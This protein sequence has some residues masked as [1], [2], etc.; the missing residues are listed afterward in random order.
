MIFRQFLKYFWSYSLTSFLLQAQAP[1]YKQTRLKNNACFFFFPQRLGLSLELS[2]DIHREMWRREVGRERGRQ[3]NKLLPRLLRVY[4]HPEAGTPPPPRRAAPRVAAGSLDSKGC[5]RACASTSG[6]REGGRRAVPHSSFGNR[7]QISRT[8]GSGCS[9]TCSRSTRR[10]SAGWASPSCCRDAASK[11]ASD[12]G[13]G[14]APRGLPSG[15]PHLSLP[16]PRRTRPAARTPPQPPRPSRRP[17]RSAPRLRAALGRV[18]SAA[19]CGAPRTHRASPRRGRSRLP[20][21]PALPPGV[22]RGP[23]G[24]RSNGPAEGGGGARRAGR[25][26]PAGLAPAAAGARDFFAEGRSA[27]DADAEE[28]SAGDG[29]RRTRTTC[30]RSRATGAAQGPNGSRRRRLGGPRGRGAG[31]VGGLPGGGLGRRGRR[32]AGSLGCGEA[33]GAEADLQSAREGGAARDANSRTASDSPGEH[34]TARVLQPGAPRGPLEFCKVKRL[35]R[36][37][38]RL[39]PSRAGCPSLSRASHRRG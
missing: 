21:A 19:S 23:R 27:A 6:C 34:E 2:T 13:V 26:G 35:T 11:P 15:R 9:K 39:E 8:S 22:G 28:R 24:V 32:A 38:V 16:R 1:S 18:A 5:A 17:A 25:G 36:K 7:S 30:W 29:P 33:P 14:W 31:K 12:T 20:A 3:W 10:K 37:P 4:E